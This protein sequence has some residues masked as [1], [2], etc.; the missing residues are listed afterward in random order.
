MILLVKLL[1]IF[2]NYRVLFKLFLNSV[3]ITVR[4]NPGLMNCLYNGSCKIKMFISGNFFIFF[5]S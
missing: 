3:L 4:F 1:M 2:K 5:A